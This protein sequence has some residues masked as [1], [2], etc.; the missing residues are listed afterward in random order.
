MY[1]YSGIQ[2]QKMKIKSD[3]KASR[4]F[5]SDPLPAMLHLLEIP[6]ASL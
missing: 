1:L 3:Y 5:P 6:Q 4:P 2:E